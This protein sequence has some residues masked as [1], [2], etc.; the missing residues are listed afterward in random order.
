WQSSL[1]HEILHGHP[2]RG[3]ALNRAIGFAP[4]ALWLP[5]DRYRATHLQHH[6]D[7]RLTDPLDDPESRY[8]T[9]EDWQRL[10][11]LGQLALR[12]Q[13]TLAGRLVI[14]PF[15]VIG[16][17]LW[18]EARDVMAGVPGRS[19]MWGEH[20]TAVALILLWLYFVCA[21]NLWFYLFVF[22]IGGTSLMLIRSFAEHRADAA[23]IKRTAVVEGH[24]PLAWLYLFNNLHAAHHARPQLSW[25]RLPAFF[26]A[27]RALFVDT[28]RGPYYSGYGEVF[29]RFL[30]RPHDRPIH[31]LGRIPAKCADAEVA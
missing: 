28:A 15:W 3:A 14:G 24:G 29:R 10:G 12:A 23:E 20:L 19:R 31:P 2:T 6:H 18:D 26:R 9:L 17:F 22:A 25:Y 13:A 16:H 30:L 5:Y 4:L 27:N 7:E 8:V 1:Q 21:M 11:T